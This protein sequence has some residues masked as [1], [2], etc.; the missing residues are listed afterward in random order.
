MLDFYDSLMVLPNIHALILQGQ[1]ELK[2]DLKPAGAV[3]ETLMNTVY[4][5]KLYVELVKTQD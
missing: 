5:E 1:S 2:N 3:Q 4:L